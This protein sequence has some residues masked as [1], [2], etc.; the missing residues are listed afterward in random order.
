MIHAPR[1]TKRSRLRRALAGLSAS[2]VL[3]APFGATFAA[4]P[5]E[6]SEAEKLVFV[7]HQLAN[8][9]VPTSLRYTFVKSGSLEP[10]FEDEVLIDVR[11]VRASG[12]S[13]SGSF[14]SGSRSVKLPDIEAA[15]ANPVVLYFLE[16]D[17]R[18]MARLTQRKT[19][20][21]FRNRVRKALVTEAQVRDTTISFEG[22]TLP[23]KEIGLAPYATDP[24]RS[25]Y[26]RYANKQYSFVLAK[27]VP[28]GVYQMRT[29]M[30]GTEPNT[31]APA[32]EEVMTLAGP[33]ARSAAAPKVPN[34]P[35]KSR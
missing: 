31:G 10:A 5:G 1:D 3:S 24:A 8:I 18:E 32:I 35:D 13:V 26:E 20:N 6:L 28:G 4:D 2:L 16:H 15:Q 12:S 23:A 25:R 33:V 17:V 14:L 29:R 34:P 19:G 27:D 30:A 9:K 21:Y 22:R 7:E 11:E